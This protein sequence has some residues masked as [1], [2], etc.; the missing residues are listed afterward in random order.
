M[1]V[2]EMCKVLALEYGQDGVYEDPFGC[3]LKIVYKNI[4]MRI[5]RKS[6]QVFSGNREVYF[7]DEHTGEVYFSKGNWEKLIKYLLD[8]EKYTNARTA[9]YNKVLLL[10]ACKKEVERNNAILSNYFLACGALAKDQGVFSKTGYGSSRHMYFV[11]LEGHSVKIALNRNS[12]Y[13]LFVWYDNVCVFSYSY[14]LGEENG[15]G[16]YIAGE[17]E[18]ILYDVA[19]SLLSA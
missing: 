7:H 14:A 8:H 17:W 12:K 1:D 6:I 16:R 15:K 3:R 4:N 13:H 11:N 10:R 19:S 5:C 18:D 9:I 2:F